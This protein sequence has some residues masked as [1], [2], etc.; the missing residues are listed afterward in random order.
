MKLDAALL[1]KSNR[2]PIAD[3]KRARGIAVTYS[4]ANITGAITIDK[5]TSFSR[6]VR[7]GIGEESGG[8]R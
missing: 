3:T 4:D 2:S 5:W 6:I 8:A 1:S 7:V